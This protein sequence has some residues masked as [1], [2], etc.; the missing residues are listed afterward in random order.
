VESCL[1]QVLVVLIDVCIIIIFSCS[2]VHAYIIHYLRKQM[3]YIMGKV[4]KQQQ[5]LDR[6]EREFIACARRYNLP[7]G[8]FP[9]VDHYRRILSEI[10]D[11]SDFKKLDK[12]MVLEMDK[13]MTH[14]IP[15]LLQKALVPSYPLRSSTP[16]Y[17]HGDMR[18]EQQQAFCGLHPHHSSGR[19]TSSSSDGDLSSQHSSPPPQQ[20]PYYR[21]P[22]S[23]SNSGIGGGFN[24]QERR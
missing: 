19:G 23:N 24:S 18:N 22:G 20:Q 6:L 1:T 15:K 4:E 16:M 11:I 7:I 13:V 17:G 2:Q 3:P 8:D 14:D 21:G 10:K 5:L 9:D 12:S